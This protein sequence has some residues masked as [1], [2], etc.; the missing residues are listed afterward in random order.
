MRKMMMGCLVV[1]AACAANAVERQLVKDMVR[2]DQA[3]IPVLALT[4]E[5]QLVP[6]RKAFRRLM[7]EWQKFRQAHAQDFPAD[8][9]WKEDLD[10]LEASL[11]KAGGIIEEGARLKEAHEAL[12]PVRQTLMRA[13]ERAGIDYFV[14]HL[15]R[16]H[17]PMEGI[18][19]KCK[20]TPAK[21][22]ST[23]DIKELEAQLRLGQ[24]LWGKVKGAEFKA[25]LLEFDDRRAATLRQNIQL[26]D[27]AITRLE[28]ALTSG[29]AE[30]IV[31]AGVALKPPFA[32]CFK[33]FGRFPNEE[34]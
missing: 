13:R 15:T 21:D 14:D 8:K 11:R 7:N 22:L 27:Q 16:F 26:E 19:L 29:D 12:E 24:K 34:A 28:K 1:F 3:Y 6:A 32:R 20:Q 4:S 18:V 25:D 31:A 17:E 10:Q 2:F 30:A 5:D 23:S 33:L 9:Q